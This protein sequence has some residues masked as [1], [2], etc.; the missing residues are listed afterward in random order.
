MCKIVT[1]SKIK[2]PCKTQKNNSSRNENRDTYVDVFFLQV[3]LFDCD[4][5]RYSDC[6]PDI[7]TGGDALTHSKH[8]ITSNATILS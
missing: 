6:S 8:T 7:L 1:P 5:V 2:H 3:N 4:I